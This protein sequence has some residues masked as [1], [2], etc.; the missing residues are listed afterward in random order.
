VE[1]AEQTAFLKELKCEQAQGY[2]FDK[3]LTPEDFL[4]RL[5]IG[6]YEKD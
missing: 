6:G 3:P 1:T 5:R 2:Y 4:E